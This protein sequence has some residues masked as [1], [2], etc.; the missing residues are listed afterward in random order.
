MK[1]KFEKEVKVYTAYYNEK[2]GTL[3]NEVNVEEV[4]DREKQGSTS[5]KMEKGRYFKEVK[6]MIQDKRRA[7]ERR[8]DALYGMLSLASAIRQANII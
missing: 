4:T 2:E 7:K 6:D 1:V 8:S 5:L 3:I